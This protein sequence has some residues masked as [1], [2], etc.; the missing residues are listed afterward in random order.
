MVN[1]IFPAIKYI[2]N[3]LITKKK[4]TP[5]PTIATAWYKSIAPIFI[6]G[7]LQY[8]HECIHITPKADKA[9]NP[10]IGCILLFK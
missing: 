3:P 10:S 1:F 8:A 4:S 6:A 2:Q 7:L 9:R 5:F